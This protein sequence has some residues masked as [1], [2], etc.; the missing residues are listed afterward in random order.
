MMEMIGRKV[1]LGFVK[2]VAVILA[3]FAIGLVLFF[4]FSAPYGDGLERTMEGAGFEE[5][6]PVYRA[7][8]D[9]GESYPVALAMGLLGFATVFALTFA[10]GWVLRKKG[11]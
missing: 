10:V 5:P 8:L 11:Q 7:P 4:I 3:A 9:Y 2:A 6:E 1:L